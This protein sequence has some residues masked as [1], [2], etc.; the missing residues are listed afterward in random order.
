MLWFDLDALGAS[1]VA[2]R[3]E[4]DLGAL[5]VGLVA[6]G[7]DPGA[8]EVDPGCL[9]GNLGALGVDL[10][11]G[12]L[13]VTLH[14]LRVHLDALGCRECIWECSVSRCSGEGEGFGSYGSGSACS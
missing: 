14:R 6:L 10:D 12:A 3:L 11:L 13:G 8:L 7:V 1:W 5:G 9:E 4:A 2:H